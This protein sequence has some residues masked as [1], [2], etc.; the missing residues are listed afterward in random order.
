MNGRMKSFLGPFKV[1]YTTL[2]LLL[3]FMNFVLQEGAAIQK[4]TIDR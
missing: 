4:V 3:I 2:S 1:L